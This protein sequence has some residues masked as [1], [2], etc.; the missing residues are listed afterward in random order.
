MLLWPQ[1]HPV[2]RSG[3]RAYGCGV[4]FGGTPS[5]L[6]SSARFPVLPILD[7]EPAQIEPSDAPAI[8]R[9][10]LLLL[11]GCPGEREDSE[12][13]LACAAAFS[14][15]DERSSSDSYDRDS[16]APT[17]PDAVAITSSA[18]MSSHL[19]LERD[20]RLSETCVC[21]T[22]RRRAR[23]CRGRRYRD[24]QAAL[25]HFLSQSHSREQAKRSRAQ[26]RRNRYRDEHEYPNPPLE[27]V[28]LLDQLTP[29]IPEQ[30]M[31]AE[32]L[33]PKGQCDPQAADAPCLTAG[34]GT[35]PPDREGRQQYDEH[36]QHDRADGSSGNNTRRWDE[37]RLSKGAV[38]GRDSEHQE[39]YDERTSH[40]RT[41][42][43][44]SSLRGF[45][46]CSRPRA[47]PVRPARCQAASVARRGCSSLGSR[48][49]VRSDRAS[50]S[51][52]P[53]AEGAP[54]WR[55]AAYLAI[56][57]PEHDPFIRVIVARRK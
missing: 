7:D 39:P 55:N 52:P 42:S 50:Q 17:R 9:Q 27:H 14:A 3:S 33:K 4:A 38:D 46:P 45:S 41:A 19:R 34:P 31:L 28:V 24:R 51:T 47:A 43:L 56:V 13:F 26:R 49:F 23:H 54:G 29:G 10:P 1:E 37:Q 53:N 2:I 5:C 30:K 25:P 36:R 57:R 8:Q 21:P 44:I 35:N 32:E 18:I 48:R 12:S 15:H 20:E 40:C 16:E 22:R 6:S 11:A